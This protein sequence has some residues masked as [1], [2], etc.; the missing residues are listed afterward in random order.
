M[1][2]AQDIKPHGTKKENH[3][4]SYRKL[5][6]TVSNVCCLCLP[7]SPSGEMQFTYQ[8]FTIVSFLEAISM[9]F[10]SDHYY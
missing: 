3:L 2:E 7:V 10:S 8:S 1:C 5:M 4:M 9:A 6:I